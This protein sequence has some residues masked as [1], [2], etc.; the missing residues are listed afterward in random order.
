[1]NPADCLP[2][3]EIL[4]LIRNQK[5]E[6][7]PHAFR[8][9]GAAMGDFRRLSKVLATMSPSQLFPLLLEIEDM[10]QSHDYCLPCSAKIRAYL[11]IFSKDLLPDLHLRY[12][13]EYAKIIKRAPN[14]Q[15][16]FFQEVIDSLQGDDNSLAAEA[17]RRS[18]RDWL[19]NQQLARSDDRE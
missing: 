3:S 16:D 15:R 2:A 7:T 5:E 14:I 19:I 12:A 10:A 8:A 17:Q 1:M 4:R 18:W 13:R 11:L 6:H 9:G